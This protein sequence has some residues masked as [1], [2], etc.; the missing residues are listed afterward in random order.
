MRTTYRELQEISLP[1]M[2]RGCAAWAMFRQ[3]AGGLLSQC[4]F[5][6]IDGAKL[7]ELNAK[8]GRRNEQI[9]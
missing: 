1:S 2:A 4:K 8:F 5:D 3:P 7:K 9:C 6:E